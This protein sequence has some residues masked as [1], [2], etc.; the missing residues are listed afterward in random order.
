MFFSSN[1]WRKS[2]WN[3]T[4]SHGSTVGNILHVM[5]DFAAVLSQANWAKLII[6]LIF[7]HAIFN[8]YVI[9]EHLPVK[10]SK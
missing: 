7:A 8:D 1:R 2:Q 10:I 6:H 5:L 4:N 3:A 9:G